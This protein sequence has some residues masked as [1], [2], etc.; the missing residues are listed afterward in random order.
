M[1]VQATINA[2]TVKCPCSALCNGRRNNEWKF[3][4]S[5]RYSQGEKAC[6]FYSILSIRRKLTSLC[7][8]WGYLASYETVTEYIRKKRLTRP[9]T[10][11]QGASKYMK[12][13]DRLAKPSILTRTTQHVARSTDW[14]ILFGYMSISF[15]PF[16]WMFRILSHMIVLMWTIKTSDNQ[17]PV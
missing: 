12:H 6:E 2:N 14:P 8:L 17:L 7:K 11:L 10:V 1:N 13:A 16:I 5:F 3:Y 15:Q 9:R 4:I